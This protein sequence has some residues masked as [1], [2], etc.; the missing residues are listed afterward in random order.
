MKT[1]GPFECRQGISEKPRREFCADLGGIYGRRVLGA[2]E[3]LLGKYR[4]AGPI[5]VRRVE[6]PISGRFIAFS[7][8]DNCGNVVVD[9]HRK[10]A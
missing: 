6:N 10:F 2:Q 8:N 7:P 1:A 4:G 9:P 3:S 5:R